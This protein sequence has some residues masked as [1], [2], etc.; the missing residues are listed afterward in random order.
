MKKVLITGAS[1][2]AGG[3]LAEY[4]LSQNQ[5]EVFGTYH[6]EK[7]LQQSPLKDRITFRQIDLM[8]A[9][10]VENLI[11][12]IRPDHIYHLAAA[13]PVAKSFEDPIQTMHTNIDSQINLLEAVKKAELRESSFM[14]AS[15]AQVYGYVQPSDLPID[16]QTSLRPANPY[17]ISKIAQDYLGFQY[18]L[19]HGLRIIR[20]RP[21]NHIGPRQSLGFVVAD[22][23]K[24]IV[25]IEKGEKEPKIQV[26]NL[27][28]KRDFT[29]VRDMVRAY[30]ML[31]EKG[32]KGEVYNIGSGKSMSVQQILD[33]LLSLS[34]VKITVSVDQERMRPSDTP[35]I[36]CDHTKI[37]SLTG[38]QPEIP[39][40]QTLKDTLE[41]WRQQKKDVL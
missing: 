37:S 14:I 19:S 25:D 31:L 11:N 41:Y 13:S 6:S 4:L 32:K 29:D 35:E 3:F 40:E 12:E 16:E 21:F 2:F 10:Q 28:A 33:M 15:S 30:A 20:V 5:F 22:F 18:A 24:Q 17:A 8:Q 39:L 9:T 36:V 34:T 38:W 23:A 1:G 7:S 27:E 26:G